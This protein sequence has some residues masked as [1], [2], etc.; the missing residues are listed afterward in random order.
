MDKIPQH[1]IN[2]IRRGACV[3]FVGAGF[4]AAAGMPRWAQLLERIINA[5]VRDGLLLQESDLVAHLRQLIQRATAETFDRTAQLLS[6][7][8]GRTAF[9]QYINEQMQIGHEIPSDM[10]MRLKLLQQIPFRAI[11][12]TNYDLLLSG[13]TAFHPD[14]PMR[15]ILRPESESFSDI[16]RY[17]EVRVP[18]VY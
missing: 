8:L 11:V 18:N 2:E 3:A 9:E 14:R 15:Q 17:K 7:K 12:T 6:D 4:T 10:L 5:G 16:S 13:V 1:L